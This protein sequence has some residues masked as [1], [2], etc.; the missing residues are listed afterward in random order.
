MSGN[1]EINSMKICEYFNDIGLI[2]YDNVNLF[3]NICTEIIKKNNFKKN[4]DIF[5]TSLFSYMKI[6]SKNEKQLFEYS[7]RTINAFYNN[8]LISKYKAI[9]IIKTIFFF[10]LKEQLLNF[11]FKLNRINNQK[12][13]SN[14]YNNNLNNEIFLKRN[15][16]L[17]RSRVKKTKLIK[18]NSEELKQIYKTSPFKNSYT[19]LP[20]YYYS[21]NYDEKECT[22]TPKINK[23]F[24]PYYDKK[25]VE[26]YTYYA[27]NF[28]VYTQ[29]PKREI[30][31][32]NIN[33]KK[34]IL[35]NNNNKLNFNQMNHSTNNLNIKD[36]NINN[37]INENG[38]FI[39]P[40]PLISPVYQISH[41]HFTFNNPYYI[42]GNSNSKK[43]LN[44]FNNSNFLKN[45]VNHLEKVNDKLLNL[46]LKKMNDIEK[47]CTFI[48]QTNQNHNKKNKNNEVPRYIQL[49][50][51]AKI[52]KNNNE[53]LREKYLKEELQNM[54]TINKDKTLSDSNYYNKLYNDAIYYKG[55]EIENEKKEN[56]KYTF[57][58][59]LY[60]N[61]K[62]NVI[63]PFNQRREKS[64][65]NKLNLLRM[66]DDE[67]KRELEDMKKNSVSKNINID[68]KE[69]V[70]RLYSKEYEKIKDK[71]QKE[72][73]QKN[74]KKQII[75]WNKVNY[76]NNIKY[77]DSKKKDFIKIEESKNKNNKEIYSNKIIEPFSLNSDNNIN[78]TNVLTN[79]GE[80]QITS[81]Q[82]RKNILMDKIKNEYSINLNSPKENNINYRKVSGN[83]NISNLKNYIEIQ[84]LSS[85]MNSI[86]NGND[87][88]INKSKY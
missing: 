12:A 8:Q 7:N 79:L 51:D 74:K 15:K 67:E 69:V 5:I 27:P 68:S 32:I 83:Y 33:D 70:D 43:K 2:D 17:N 71:I 62:Y 54:Q 40:I 1:R 10:K 45:E 38:E 88:K 56:E 58:P 52:R 60:K 86:V 47:N 49:H 24:K 41:K 42:N 19:S 13:K 57:S 37:L 11:L 20:K 46:K 53:K 4:S 3:L 25:P 23:N 82:P 63:M 61:N 30:P 9:R 22:F 78:N 36:I 34:L 26:S 14:K 81:K 72:K 80:T 85:D 28:D 73:E 84:S 29:I 18:N 31:N 87:S 55:R 39:S 66:K 75:D 64:I 35:K 65:E 76:E 48:P 6:I 77:S 50:N 21:V 44:D 59:H 16:N